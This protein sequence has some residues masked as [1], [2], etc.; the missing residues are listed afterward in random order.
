MEKIVKKLQDGVHVIVIACDIN[1]AHGKDKKIYL[2]VGRT[3]LL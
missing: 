3:K 2:C 1:G